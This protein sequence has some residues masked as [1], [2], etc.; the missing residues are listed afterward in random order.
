VLMQKVAKELLFMFRSG[1]RSVPDVNN[2]PIDLSSQKSLLQL[3]VMR[4]NQRLLTLA[5][6]LQV[7][8][9]NFALTYSLT[10]LLC[11]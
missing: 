8:S 3:F 4:E 7:C 11:A 9:T 6:S 1:K 5:M 10:H 2:D